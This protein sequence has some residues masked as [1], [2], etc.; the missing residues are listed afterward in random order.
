M[1]IGS[2]VM[3]T[4]GAVTVRRGTSTLHSSY[5]EFYPPA[6][7]IGTVAKIGESGY[8][9]EDLIMVQWPSGTTSENNSWWCYSDYLLE[10]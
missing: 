1:K 9:D 2:I 8:T 10:L 7:T 6:K 5:P 4:D 3:F